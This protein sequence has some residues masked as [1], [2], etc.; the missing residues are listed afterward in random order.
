MQSN[1]HE[2]FEFIKDRRAVD[3]NVYRPSTIG[4]RLALRLS[5][6]GMPDYPSY[7]AYVKKTPA[8][9]DSL[10]DV[11]TIK[12]SGF[13]RNSMVFDVLRETVLPKLI[14]TFKGDVF[15]VW[16]VGCAKGEEAYS[17]AILLKE[18]AEKEALPSKPFIIA[19]DI[20]REALAEAERAVYK[21][22]RLLEVKKKYLDRY[23]V[24]KERTYTVDQEIWS[25]VTFACHDVTSGRPPKEGIFSNYHLILCRNL[26]IYLNRELQERVLEQTSALLETGGILVLGEAET[27]HEKNLLELMPHTKIYRKGGPLP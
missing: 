13:F 16:C 1:Y 11:L 6:V 15:R 27:A 3:F 17:V 21:A 9:L 19:T 22:E 14:E 4:R 10:I 24:R 8:E 23:F 18:I 20:D 25:L 26:L 12:V 2:L 7:L 5:A